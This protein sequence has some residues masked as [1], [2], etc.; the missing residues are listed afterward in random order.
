MTRSEGST[1]STETVSRYLEDVARMLG[2][3]DPAYRAEVLAGVHDH[4]GAALGPQP[5]REAE[6]LQ[7]LDRLGPP[8]EIAAAALEDGQRQGP[9]V[10]PAFM[11]RTWVPPVAVT[12]MA[13]GLL[14]VLWFFSR[15]YAFYPGLDRQV[16]VSLPEPFSFLRGFLWLLVLPTTWLVIVGALLV[17]ISPLYRTA[18]RLAAWLAVPWSAAIF[19]LAT[20][21]LRATD[22]CAR[23]GSGSCTGVDTETARMAMVAALVIAAIGVLLLLI[24]LGRGRTMSRRTATRWWT[25]AAVTLGLLVS[26]LPV[27]LLPV[28][29]REGTYVSHGADGLVAYPWTFTDT[30]VPVLVIVPVWILTLVLLVRSPLWK[31]ATKVTCAALLPVLLAVASAVT[32][33]PT[34]L[35]PAVLTAGTAVTIAGATAVILTAMGIF[36]SSQRA[37]PDEAS[38]GRSKTAG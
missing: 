30:L 10:R 38:D 11:A 31:R 4:L 15:F 26:A 29:Y 16:F 3:V 9:K 14:G 20:V 13:L 12:T 6:V 22:G 33:A 28:T 36:L 8:E 18:D 1:M 35:S 19:E 2:E 24:R 23:S 5:W 7:A 32:V 17:T 34:T 27:V 25:A 37:S 21:V